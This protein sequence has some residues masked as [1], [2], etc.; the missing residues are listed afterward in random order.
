MI[1]PILRR[2]EAGRL[3]SFREVSMLLQAHDADYSAL[4]DTA[5][6]VCRARKGDGV[7]FRTRI[8]VEMGLNAAHTLEAVD[9]AKRMGYSSVILEGDGDLDSEEVAGLVSRIKRTIPIHISLCLGERSY[10]DYALW[11]RSGAEQYILPHETCN[12]KSYAELFPGRSPSD[13]LARYLWLRGLGYQV[14]GGLMANCMCRDRVCVVD[15]IEVLMNVGM[16]SVFVR[17]TE[18]K[19]EMYRLIAVLRVCLPTADIWLATSQPDARSRSLNCGANT[20]VTRLPRLE[21]ASV[22]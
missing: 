11:R 14:G 20:I 5:G 4:L 21:P 7:S 22:P 13:R 19:D 1:G 12:P 17:P 16:D 6:R 2:A 8:P 15:D 10:D 9:G 3:P 18:D